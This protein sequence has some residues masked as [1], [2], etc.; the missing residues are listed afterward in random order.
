MFAFH[1]TSNVSIHRDA[2]TLMASEEWRD[3]IQTTVLPSCQVTLL[4]KHLHSSIPLSHIV[5]ILFLSLN[6]A[7]LKGL[8]GS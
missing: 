1:H 2:V 6:V 8:S 3:Q 5:C 4:S 7:N